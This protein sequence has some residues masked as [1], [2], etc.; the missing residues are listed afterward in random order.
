M[1]MKSF[2]IPTIVLSL[3]LVSSADHGM[4]SYE[5]RGPENWSKL[6][7][8]YELCGKGERQSPINFDTNTDKASVA[9]P[10]V[11]NIKNVQNG[12]METG[13]TVKLIPHQSENGSIFFDSARYDFQEVHF[14]TP[15]E[16]HINGMHTDLEA[17]FV[18]SNTNAKTKTVIGVLYEVSPDGSSFIESII[19]KVS[20][21]FFFA[22]DLVFH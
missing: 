13:H 10:D 17:H 5:E 19:L 9:P 3:I 8:K 16:H 4:F 15:S 11:H 21:Y 1:L 2:L 14:H 22:P 18:F 7:K 12:K 6:D 20:G